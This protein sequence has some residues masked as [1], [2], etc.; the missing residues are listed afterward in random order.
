MCQMWQFKELLKIDESIRFLIEHQL[1]LILHSDEESWH[2]V[3]FLI[4]IREDASKIVE[5]R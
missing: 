5:I 4:E 3:A 1:P 2:H